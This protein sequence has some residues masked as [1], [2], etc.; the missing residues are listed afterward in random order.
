MVNEIS[1]IKIVLSPGDYEK[2]KKQ[3]LIE[4]NKILKEQQDKIEKLKQLIGEQQE[5][6]EI[7]ENQLLML[8]GEYYE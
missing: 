3:K 7:Y 5:Q 8:N 2:V 6:I 1:G 4:E